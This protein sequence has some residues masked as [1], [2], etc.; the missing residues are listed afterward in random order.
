MKRI[1][2]LSIVAI[3]LA[4]MPDF[5]QQPP[6]GGWPRPTLREDGL[7]PTPV[8]PSVDPN[9]DMYFRKET[10]SSST[11]T[12][13]G[14]TGSTKSSASNCCRLGRTPYAP[15]ALTENAP[16]RR[17]TAAAS[18][19][20]KSCSKCS[21]NRDTGDT[22]SYAN[23]QEPASIPASFPSRLST[24]TSPQRAAPRKSM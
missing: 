7:D 17:K 2:G 11:S 9:I 4:A 8:D 19:A 10:Q 6:R 23:G 13:S 24:A 1:V 12:T 15:F 14:I 5:A 18:M 21:P 3:C 20:T 22:G 16:A